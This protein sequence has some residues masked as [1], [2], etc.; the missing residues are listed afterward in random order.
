MLG[1]L[2]THV[3][4]SP[5]ALLDEHEAR[6]QAQAAAAA[7]SGVRVPQDAH[8]LSAAAHAPQ[9]LAQSGP[10][11]PASHPYGTA[12]AAGAPGYRHHLAAPN[13]A[14]TAAPAL[15][16][17]YPGAAHPAAAPGMPGSAPFSSLG[18]LQPALWPAQGVPA[19]AQGV[20]AASLAQHGGA[21]QP[22]AAFGAG[23]G[24]WGQPHAAP[25]GGLQQAQPAGAAP[26]SSQAAAPGLFQPVL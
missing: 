17:G 20:A 8:A 26:G 14:V 23:P 10:G 15:G 7:P 9:G 3:L 16:G 22:A 24:A 19:L 13:L 25:V 21:A 12:L 18:A 11:R 2:N 6:W 5:G 4:W 1:L